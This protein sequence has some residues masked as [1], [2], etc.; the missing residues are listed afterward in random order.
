[1]KETTRKNNKLKLFWFSAFLKD[2][3]WGVWIMWITLLNLIDDDKIFR[4]L[5]MT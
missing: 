3:K 5:S 4:N 1:M 2:F